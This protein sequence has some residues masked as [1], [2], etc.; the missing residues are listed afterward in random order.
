VTDIAELGIKIESSDIR[1]AVK[2][3]DRLENQSGKTEK[4]SKGLSKGFKALGAVVSAVGFA[5]LSASVANATMKMQAIHSA[6]RVATDSSEEAADMFAFIREESD[7]L[8]LSLVDSADQ[9]AKLAVAAK[10]TSLEGQGARDI[11]VAVSEAS[12][13]MGLSAA[14]TSGAL[15]AVGVS[16][17]KI[18]N[19][20]RWL[21]SGPR[22]GI[23]EI[24]DSKTGVDFG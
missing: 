14:E 13:A 5:A 1:D 3:L 15:K 6:M 24:N 18:A 16:L 2:E 17:M 23:G 11:F 7:R 10:G 12:T 20:I 8:G 9:F 4:A 19:N 22:C 21:S